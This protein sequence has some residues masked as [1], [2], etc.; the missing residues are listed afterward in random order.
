MITDEG[1]LQMGAKG[2]FKA[3]HIVTLPSNRHFGTLQLSIA[4]CGKDKRVRV[5]H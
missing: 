1:G 2:N 4:I 5:T 3:E